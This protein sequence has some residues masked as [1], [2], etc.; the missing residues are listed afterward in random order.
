MTVRIGAVAAH[1]R[2]D[3][4]HDLERIAWAVRDAR[5]QA[6]DLLVLPHGA[7]GGYH[8]HLAAPP[9]DPAALPP[10]VRVDGDEI[11]AV[12]ASAGPLVVCLGLTERADG[13]RANTA[14]CLSGDGV[15]GVHRKVHLPLGERAHYRAGRRLAAVDTPVGRLG[16]LVDYDKTFPEA[17][18]ALALDGATVLANPCAW[19]ASR[20]R[21]TSVVRDRQRRLFDLYDAAR[22]AENQVVLVSANQ[23]GRHGTLQFFGCSK[24]VRPDGET[25]AVTGAR[26]GMATAELDPTALVAE[27]RRTFHHVTEL[28]PDAYRPRD[29]SPDATASS[30]AAPGARGSDPPGAAP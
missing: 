27:A 25:V 9:D 11:A 6:L 15:L 17:A 26:A 16:L 19:P 21:S 1:F 4:A 14:V 12:V 23:T 10:P 18:R 7:L 3:L 20:T 22:A 2:R 30:A 24:V 8:D 28:R 29:R 5:Q 13:A